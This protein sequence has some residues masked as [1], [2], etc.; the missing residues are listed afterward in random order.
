MLVDLHSH[1]LPSM[2]DG[3]DSVEMSVAMLRRMGEQGVDTVCATSHYCRQHDSIEKFC[4][5]RQD[6]FEKLKNALP[7]NVPQIL[8][9]AEVAFFPEIGDCTELD[10][11]CIEGTKTL[12]L[13]MPFLQWTQPQVDE[14]ASLVLD[15]QYQVVLV[16]PER[17]CFTDANLDY[18]SRLAELPIGMQVN[19]S[20]LLRWR[21]R[22]DGLDLLQM[23]EIPLLGSDCHDLTR[24]PPNLDRGREV[25]RRKLGEVF[26]EEIDRNAQAM[27]REVRLT[28]KT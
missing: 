18:L 7:E 9:A 17:F 8:L 5:R 14:V 12:L 21:T 22:R 16:H 28:G 1:V 4:A 2:D 25:V 13:E 20:T 23:C 11:L 10:R 3:S 27:V 19:A 6:A 24:R 15:R 26:L